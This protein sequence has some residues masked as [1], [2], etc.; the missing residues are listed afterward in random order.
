LAEGTITPGEAD[1]IAY[2]V[3]TFIQTIETSDF[4]RRSQSVET[5]F[6]RRRQ[7]IRAGRHLAGR[8]YSP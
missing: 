4:E 1:R 3:D 2:L 5:N 7:G 8:H 6:A